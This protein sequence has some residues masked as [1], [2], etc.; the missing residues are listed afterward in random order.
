MDL[1][2]LVE[3]EKK[4]LNVKAKLRRWCAYLFIGWMMMSVPAT[5]EVILQVFNNTWA[6]IIQKIPEYAEV[7][8]TTLW[9]P[10]P[11][12]AGS[13]WSVGYDLFDPFDLGGV[14]QNG[15]VKTRYGTENELKNLMATAHRFGMRV[16]F[17]NIMNHR[18]YHIP[19]YDAG[20]PLDVYPGMLP[21]DFHLQV[22]PE[23][24]YRAWPD[25]VNWGSTW[26]IQNY[27]LSGLIDISHEE[28]NANFGQNPG[29]THPRIKF[30]RHPDNPEFYAYMPD[31]TYV[32]FNSTNIT[33]NT[34]ANDGWYYEEDVSAYLNRSARW[35]VE[36]TKCDGL[37]LDAVKHV[38][39]YFFGE[40]WA[41]DKDGDDSGYCGQAQV[42][43]NLSRGF[44]DWDNH[45][46]TVFDTEL[47]FGRNDLMMFGEHMGE[48]P[49]Y[50]DYWAAGMRLLDA[51][52][53]STL[54]DRLGNEW[55]NL[56]GLDS[57]DYIEGVQM[58]QNLG[59]YYAKSHDDGIA[60]HE[61]LH[62]AFNLTRAGLPDVYTDGNRQAQTLGESGG[63]F[64]RHANTRYLGQWG[65][66]RIPNLVHLH[67]QF[68]RS[69]QYP[70]GADDDVVAYDRV[71]T[72][73]TNTMS[74]ADGCVMN[75]MMNDN[76]ADGAYRE[77]PT[78]FPDDAYL[79]QYSTGGGNFYTQVDSGKIKVTI[80]PG[81]YFLFSWRSPEESTLWSYG[82]GNPLTIYE[83][84]SECD[85]M[86]Y[87]RYDGPDGDPNFNPYASSVTTNYGYKW[88]VPRVT[89]ATNLR[90]ATR[91]DGS[92]YSV[93]FK[94]DG[95]MDLNGI[96]HSS[97]DMRDH[98]PGN[99]GSYDV[100]LGYEDATFGKRI[101]PEKF[102][103]SDT[104]SNTV[105][106]AGS[107]SYEMTIG[108]AGININDGDGAN[109]YDNTQGAAFVYHDPTANTDF[110][111]NQFWP[112][113]TNA[114]NQDL[115]IQVKTGQAGDINRVYLYYTIDGE[116]WPEGAGGETIGNNTYA[117]EMYWTTNWVDG[118]DT[119]DWWKCSISGGFPADTV[120]RY[121]IG[122]TREQGYAGAGWYCPFPNS[123]YDIGMKTKMMGL[124]NINDFN[125]TTNVYF[126]HNDWGNVITGLV[127]GFH[128]VK[129][130][131]FLQR[132]N[133]AP[134]YDTY[135]QP[136]Y[137]DTEAV[138]GE[139]I[140][141]AESDTLYDNEY[142]CLLRTDWTCEKVYF[143]IEDEDDTNDDA[144]TGRNLGN[145]TNELGA[146]AWA[147]ASENIAALGVDTIY[148]KEWR[149][150]YSNIPSN[151]T[152]TIYVKMAELSSST[153]YM[154]TATNGHFGEIIRNV[155]AS[156][157]GY[158]MF[159]AWPQNNGDTVGEDYSMKVYFSKNLWDT[160][161]TTVKNRFLISLDGET[162][163]KDNYSLTWDGGGDYHSLSYSL[164]DMYDGS[165]E[166]VH[167]IVVTHTNA[168]GLGVTLTATREVLAWPSSSGPT[169]QIT[170]PPEY[171]SDGAR[172]QIILPD[173]AVPA[174]TERMY[175]VTVQTDTT[176]EDVWISFTNNTSGY[177]T[178]ITATNIP[179]SN[180]V[181]VTYGTNLVLGTNFNS[182]LSAGN[183][184]LI[185]SNEVIVA[186]VLND[187][188]LLLRFNWD[189]STASNAT[190]YRI[191]GNPSIEGSAY[192]WKFWWTNMTEGSFTFVANATTNT[193]TYY[194]DASAWRNA[195]VIFR[196]I[197][198][199]STNDVDDDDD[200]I[201]DTD[202]T[203]SI[204]LPDTNSESWTNSVVHQ[205]YS[206]GKTD[207][208]MPDTDG[209]G[210]PDGL[211]L[212]FRAPTSGTDT[213]TDTNG[214][215]YPNFIVDLDPPVYNTVPDNS[216]MD[217]YNLN[218]S[219]TD[220]LMGSTTD[221]NNPDSDYD[222]LK[223]GIEDANR[224]GW[225]DGDN[226]ALTAGW[227][228]WP[229]WNYP[230]GVWDAAWTETSPN[231]ADS[232]DMEK[233]MT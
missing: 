149:F 68:S 152:G 184:L 67:N 147:E 114:A 93:M 102:A 192:I 191:G 46:D 11:Q 223:D 40:Q 232:M 120:L 29:D 169:I 146:W 59:V 187:T 196:E 35:L 212:G 44:S 214:D 14:D 58:G 110:G 140:Y 216:G 78:A 131:A 145:G 179:L 143:H 173:V 222:G 113:P 199:A 16:Y 76:Y 9:L 112:D 45:R 107:G 174:A 190:A 171:D 15:S 200:G 108:S 56:N 99:V 25:T 26:E 121:K 42:Q 167:D 202:E 3:N 109:D 142:G 230:D 208:V 73:V 119:N 62:N 182:E 136:F 224:N 22:T 204:D 218:A 211:E 63:A 19:G 20:T 139:L 124:W 220:Q 47:D 6:E 64:P 13:I 138:Q 185:E 51:R 82:G 233:T 105:G 231:L 34:I 50:S 158:R 206:F 39:G 151:G 157:P 77:V 86:G 54:N 154:E 12:K 209:D 101:G 180:T 125:A 226:D 30:V 170:D 228:P 159:V 134:I 17:D 92:A 122:V 172:F 96:A 197:V 178:P 137:L 57:A 95:G 100:F 87:W 203:T 91:V 74:D 213:N 193:S 183:R 135:T 163:G 195:T 8:Y 166:N 41:G 144:E 1:S 168:A 148:P 83:N 188:N 31:D 70:R 130:R 129:S 66:N 118:S 177:I 33:T 115:W 165:P 123:E 225:V 98:P 5:A 161:E 10:P 21:E 210:L 111:E 49:P 38:P 132:P 2:I 215:G 116:T 156:G 141:P 75:F 150:N 71:D 61:E 176:V 80:P 18:G 72:R 52:T 32:G 103:S 217:G 221:P 94:L 207:P 4:G 55:K 85:W 27:W 229:A 53:H 181:L 60:N 160:D 133:Q 104:Q 153:N 28:P 97:G 84:G 198:T 194:V 155:N 43:F 175:Q 164:P 90:F 37:R 127:D 201:L 162:Q 219:R 205:W 36:E 23:G 79:W 7:G 65:D 128:V 69:W 227:D 189:Q 117:T 89:V 186:S 24:F 88:W 48:P 81:G 106:S 126:Q